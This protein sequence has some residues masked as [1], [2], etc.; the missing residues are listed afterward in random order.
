MTIGQPIQ[1]QA[2]AAA[3]VLPGFVAAI[4]RD[5]PGLLDVIYFEPDPE[6]E[7]GALAR[8]ARN[9]RQAGTLGNSAEDP[10][11]SVV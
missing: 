8:T 7:G 5:D 4:D 11:W 6:N 3:P 2:G 9:I 1:F 10:T